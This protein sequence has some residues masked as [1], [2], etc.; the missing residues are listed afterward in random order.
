M[1]CSAPAATDILAAMVFWGQ[2]QN[3]MI[4]INLDVLIPYMVEVDR[5][6][7][8][9]TD[10]EYD[11]KLDNVTLFL[12]N[13]SP[14]PET[15]NYTTIAPNATEPIVYSNDTTAAEALIADDGISCKKSAPQEEIDGVQLA[16]N[17]GPRYNWSSLEQGMVLHAFSYGHISTLIL[18]G[19]LADCFGFKWVYGI[20]ASLF[21]YFLESYLCTLC[22]FS[23]LVNARY[24]K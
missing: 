6:M 14:I 15:S 7:D 21:I 3:Y 11:D 16:K 17:Y 24:F 5:P 19:R 23:K 9:G 2:V 4:R 1:K 20:G 12:N 13:T 10:V 8:E 22:T 18:G